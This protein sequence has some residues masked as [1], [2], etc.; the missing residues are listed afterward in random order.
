MIH[1]KKSKT[2]V[3]LS[4]RSTFRYSLFAILLLNFSY[5][6]KAQPAFYNGSSGTSYN[7]F[8]LNSGTNKVQ[9]IYGPSLFNS[10][11]ATGT[12]ASSGLISKIYFR[13]GSTVSSSTY[14][15]FTILLGQN[16]GTT[17]SWSSTTFVTGLTTAFYASSFTMTG[18]TAT[19]WYAITLST[20]F[21]YDPSKS[22]VFELKV[23]AGTGNQ[24]A[25]SS[26]SGN[27]RNWG[28]YSGNTGSIGSGLVDFGFDIKAS[29]NDI[30]TLGITSLTNTCGASSDPVILQ[31]K[32]TGVVDIATGQNIPVKTVVTGAG[33]A[34]FNRTYNK[35]LKIGV[36]D[37]IHM[38]NLNSAAI[39][40][41][42]N[43][44]SWVSFALDSIKQNDT[45]TTSKTF[46]GP[47][48]PTLD[49]KI[50]MVCDTVKFTNAT[51]D[52][53]NAAKSY[54]W[55]FGNAKSS[56]SYSVNHSYNS[57]GTYNVKL[58]VYYGTGLI[59][60]L[61]KQVIVYGKPQAY[62]Y[63]NNQCFNTAIDFNNF[64]SGVA[65]Y[66]WSFGDA[67][68]STNT[69]PSKTYAAAGTYAVKLVATTANFCKDSTTK[70]VI[71][72]TK[73]IPSFSVTNACIGS[74]VFFNNASTGGTSYSWDLGDGSS[75][76]FFN[77]SKTY[78]T[79]GTYGIILTVFSAQGC[80]DKVSNTVTIHPLPVSNFTAPSNCKGIP[81]PFTNTSTGSVSQS[82]AFGNSTF[83]FL[84][85]PS[86]TYFATGTYNVILTV[87]S[88]DGC[89]H[90][91]TK[92]VTIYANPKS[93][94]TAT[95]VCIG[96]NTDFTNKSTLPS[97]GGEYLWRFG[98]G[99]KSTQ[100]NPSY[101]YGA[102]GSY[103]VR[104]IT[105][106]SFGCKDSAETNISVF[107]KP[108]AGFTTTDV[109]DG[110]AVKFTNTSTGASSVSWDFGDATTDN[111]ASPSHMYTGPDDY[112]VI[113]SVTSADNCKDTYEGGVSVRPKP[114]VVFFAED[115]CHG[116][117]TNF[118]NL[119]VGA[120]SFNWTF[121]DGDSAK[122][123]QASHTY[124]T[125]GSYTI[126]LKGVSSKG[127]SVEQSK[128]IMVFPRPV[129]AFSAPTVCNGLITPFTNSS[130]GASTYA[131]SF[132]DGSG[133]STLTNPTY[134]YFN[135]GDYKVTLTTVSSNKCKEII[136]KTITVAS[137][138]IPI[139]MVQDV[140]NGIEVKPTNL[141]Q[142]SISSQKWDFGN[143]TTDLSTSP[144]YTYYT[145]G[146]YT[147]K[148]KVSSGLGCTDST[149][150]TILIYS[151]PII[152]TS[153]NDVI[154]K[155]HSIQLEAKGG[156]DY[157]WS[158]AATL[159]NPLVSNPTATPSEE[160]RYM[161]IVTNSFGCFD[162]AYVTIGL[163][164]DFS[165]EP[166]NLISPNANGQN[167]VWKI[168]GIEFYPLAK[169]MIFDQ[170]GRILLEQ[171]EYKN[172]WDGTVDGKPLPDG[173]YFY[174]ITQPGFDREYK[175]TI[176][177]LKN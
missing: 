43:L 67:T 66:K 68:T 48:K 170:W 14:T 13:L 134:Q 37:T 106:T 141:S 150:K 56:T 74:S 109:C 152:K 87:N 99:N 102:A 101:K 55:D 112:K 62:F 58:Y 88:K 12:P 27:Q 119:S 94:F 15:D 111:T 105:T 63:A 26:P 69:N 32:N 61:T 6:A 146:I 35:A 163:K 17:N 64:T 129:P 86:I 124:L 33:S 42:V 164:D 18:A 140:C 44:K 73:P 165:I 162:T 175:G 60:S 20:P 52:N 76:G 138:P 22:L 139:F 142:G 126:K 95:D 97:G 151:N 21:Q 78:A 53:C 110:Q 30:T 159:D 108:I 168:K 77:P 154:S 114:E 57:P 155:G 41:A 59:D 51:K 177:I 149:S 46:T 34:T 130:T 9:W 1:I 127:C 104:V 148:L 107:D 157:V 82:W 11:G 2:R 10:A 3:Q 49:F 132:G 7:A 160:T 4:F 19:S 113:L 5:L 81:T 169:V 131:W 176:N 167:D 115:H 120:A 54:K 118:N 72:Y 174:V 83:S 28:T 98:D 45:N 24:V 147:I 93:N 156:S 161:V 117:E 90:S 171:T 84:S 125:D 79:A 122:S 65:T 71:V 89:S 128:S 50:N 36:T 100:A 47:T 103:D 85:S 172:T 38:G 145:P 80:S 158:P 29:K 133:N 144:S 143:G 75:S 23:S 8:P 153:A 173:T 136:T 116:T 123:T 70:N 31:I 40:G 91:S 96:F 135:A 166:Q 92:P 137:S 39:T 121:G 25:Q 16:Q